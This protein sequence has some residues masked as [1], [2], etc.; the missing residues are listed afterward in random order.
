MMVSGLHYQEQEEYT[1]S[2]LG[3]EEEEEE[4]EFDNQTSDNLKMKE[5][6]VPRTFEDFQSLFKHQFEP[7]FD[8]SSDE[9]N[10]PHEPK[11]VDEEMEKRVESVLLRRPEA[12]NPSS[13][14]S[15]AKE[16]FEPKEI[17]REI[18]EIKEVVKR[19]D[20]ETEDIPEPE[21]SPDE[22]PFS[23][24]DEYEPEEQEEFSGK[25]QNNFLLQVS[26]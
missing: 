12:I 2:E 6:F 24:E 13:S 10:I 5:A 19:E 11:P 8:Y 23:Q 15:V 3:K 7:D 18:E 21:L 22:G 16:V 20:I 9:Q 25:H 14:R 17:E 1:D 4:Q 26:S